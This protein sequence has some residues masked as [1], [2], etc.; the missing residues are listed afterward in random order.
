MATGT[1]PGQVD[2]ARDAR[3]LMLTQWLDHWASKGVD[4]VAKGHPCRELIDGLA[5][6][7]ATRRM[8][9]LLTATHR[10]QS[11]HL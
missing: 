1:C 3:R 8:S 9:E 4:M 7:D 2:D 11:V 6:Y 10:L 5:E